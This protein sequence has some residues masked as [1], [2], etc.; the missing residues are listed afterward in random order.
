[1]KN[2]IRQQFAEGKLDHRL[3]RS[4]NRRLTTGLKAPALFYGT[5]NS[6]PIFLMEIMGLRLPDYPAFYYNNTRCAMR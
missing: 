4:R 3:T 5:A 1:M 2:K 6:K